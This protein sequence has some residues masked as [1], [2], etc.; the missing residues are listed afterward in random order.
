MLILLVYHLVETVNWKLSLALSTD[1]VVSEG[2]WGVESDSA[3]CYCLILLCMQ[4]DRN[5]RNS[6]L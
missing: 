4:Q 2:R 3:L 6:A 5:M 1:T